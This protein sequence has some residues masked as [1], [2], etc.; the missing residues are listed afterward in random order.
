M[1]LPTLRPGQRTAEGVPVFRARHTFLKGGLPL[2]VIALVLVL[3]SFA[4]GA[5]TPY[6]SSTSAAAPTIRSDKDDYTPGETV[7][8]TGSNWQPGETVHIFVNDDRGQTWSRN[9]DVTAD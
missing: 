4:H 6:A 2:A 8:L 5:L 3:T 9:V 1:H 7:T